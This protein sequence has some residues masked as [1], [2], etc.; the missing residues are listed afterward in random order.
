MILFVK[1]I[2]RYVVMGQL[3]GFQEEGKGQTKEIIIL[4][5]GLQFRYF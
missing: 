5:G 3:M 4:Y 2:I 1:K